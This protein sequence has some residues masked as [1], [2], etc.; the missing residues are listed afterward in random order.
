MVREVKVETDYSIKTILRH[1]KTFF[2]TGYVYKASDWAYPAI[3]TCEELIKTTHYDYVFTKDYPSEIVG[4]YLAKKYGIRWIPTWN[5]PYMWKKYP[6][7]YGEGT[8]YKE[9]FFYKKLIKAI[10]R[11]SYKNIFPS[12]RLRD[13]M[14]KYMYGMKEDSC[15][16]MPH[17]MLDNYQM[18]DNTNKDIHPELRIIHA[19]ALGKE[20]DPEN[21][22]KALRLLLNDNPDARIRVTLMGVDERSRNGHMNDLITRYS[23]DDIVEFIP[24]VS[25]ADSFNVM[26][27][28]DV[29][30][31]IEAA[32]EVGIF[33]PSKVADYLQI[34]KP[35]F[36]I[37]PKV[38]VLRDLYKK[39]VVGYC[40]NVTDVN[41]IKDQLVALLDDYDKGKLKHSKDKGC[42]SEMEVKQ[43]HISKILV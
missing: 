3:K 12:T 25:Y 19:G 13:Y 35:V 8:T 43:I 23:L 33:L 4:V 11:Y 17:I 30:L 16:I 37:S 34:D 28:Y 7:P 1:I 38:G 36:S 18:T 31:I 40:A 42:F 22:F 10:G 6:A 21:L 2:K 29:C 32:C 14:L 9:S 26:S 41:D 5:D 39:R 15:V 24:P 27:G 20:R